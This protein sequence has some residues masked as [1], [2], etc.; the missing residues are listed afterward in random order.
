MSK[1]KFAFMSAVMML[2]LVMATACGNSK[3]DVDLGTT[4]K[5]SYTNSYFGVSLK[6]PEDWQVQDAE[7]MNELANA[8]KEVIAG[9]NDVKKK[10]LDLAEAK[11]LNLLM[12]SKYPLDGGQVGPSTMIVAEKVSMLQGVKSGK[13]YLE[14]SKKLM[15]ESQLPYDF[16]EISTTKVGGKD[17]DLMQATI[18]N[19]E[20]LITQDYYSAIIDGYAF[21]FIFTYVD[22]ATKA[23][24]DKILSSVEFK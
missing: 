2:V 6:F 23:E 21:N 5:G 9:N 20:K 4:E 7:G 16:K 17:M 24:T 11:T 3:K 19:G 14:A 18:N 15:V 10:Q 22:E 1:K 12:T 8:G 13:D